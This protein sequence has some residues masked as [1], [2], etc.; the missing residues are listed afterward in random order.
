MLALAVHVAAPTI[1]TDNLRDFPPDQLEPLGIEAISAD[2]FV[3]AQVDLHPY[4]VVASLDA[5]ATRRRRSPKTRADLATSLG[6][7]LPRAMAELGPF[8]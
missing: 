8:V 4:E 5:M 2:A 1:V 3:L 6:R 7:P